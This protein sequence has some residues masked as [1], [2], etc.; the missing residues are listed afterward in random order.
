MMKFLDQ[1]ELVTIILSE[2]KQMTKANTV[3]QLY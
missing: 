3:F 2:G 1:I